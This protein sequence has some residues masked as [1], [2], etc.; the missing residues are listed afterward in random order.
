MGIAL[1]DSFTNTLG[2][3]HPENGN[4]YFINTFE[5]SHHIIE[6]SKWII[7]YKDFIDKYTTKSWKIHWQFI[8][9]KNYLD[10][11][12]SEINLKYNWNIDPII[13]L[14]KLYKQD[15]LSVN[16]IHKRF[17]HIFTCDK[18]RLHNFL[19]NTLDWNMRNWNEGTTISNK[20]RSFSELQKHNN[21]VIEIK[22]NNLSREVQNI[23]SNFGR[24]NIS[25]NQISELKTK[26]EKILHLLAIR[27]QVS[28]LNVLKL[29]QNLHQNHN[30]W[31]DIISSYM[32]EQIEDIEI[33]EEIKITKYN[34]RNILTKK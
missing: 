32:N 34:I 26:R 11:L 1:K 27:F 5:I 28:P 15:E 13:Y 18:S 30:F 31:Y 14:L 21:T 6:K 12:S 25:K 9:W 20:K 7:H 10:T 3:Y 17:S 29:I 4:T 24:K 23:L 19:S 2:T 33:N 22:R 16:E 8:Q